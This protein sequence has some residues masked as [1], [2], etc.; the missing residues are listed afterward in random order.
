MLIHVVV[1]DGIQWILKPLL[2]N[3]LLAPAEGFGR[4]FFLLF[5]QK[6]EQ[7]QFCDFFLFFFLAALVFFLGYRCIWHF[8]SSF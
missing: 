5:L 6:K 2:N 3:R 7:K 1:L 8:L 4:G